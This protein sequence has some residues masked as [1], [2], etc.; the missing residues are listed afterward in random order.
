MAEPDSI[1]AA[2]DRQIGWCD[3][4]GSPFTAALLRRL[5]DS[6]AQDGPAAALLRDW[7][8]DPLADALALR[9]A[10]GLHA[11]VLAGRAPALAA[12]WPPQPLPAPADFDA[13]LAAALTAHADWLRGFLASAPQTNEVGRAGVLLG[14]FLTIAQATGLPLRLLEIG[15]SAGLN[16]VWDRFRYRLGGLDWGDADSPVQL[17]P[18]WQGPTPPRAALRVATRE[19]CDL[20][21]I[22]LESP[23]QRLRLRAYVWADQRDRLA[24][25]EGA[26]ALARAA[27]LRVAAADAAA[28][29]APRLAGTAPG[30][31]TVLY[32][33]IMWQYL[34]GA[35]QQAILEQLRQAGAR[36]SAAAPLAW[37]RLEPPRPEA[38]PEL[39]LTLWPGGQ[40]HRLAEAHAHGASVTWFGAG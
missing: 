7:P 14:G 10:G 40:E 39:R 27:G 31:A 33:S 18:D 20:A 17:Q 36:A 23:E 30:C 4:L 11:L 29:L 26:I 12:A 1:L 24:R 16:T 15:A 37:L 6:L 13:L 22:D 28:W 5:R 21:P 32:H 19:A 8:G 38:R 35:T 9:L 34:P 2:F 3:T 25:L